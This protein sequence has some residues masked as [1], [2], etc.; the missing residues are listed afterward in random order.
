M[1][2][3]TMKLGEV[4]YQ[5]HEPTPK[6]FDRPSGKPDPA[7]PVGKKNENRY[8]EAEDAECPPANKVSR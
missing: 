5:S 1:N 2:E 8:A 3:E 4:M 6:S 7:P